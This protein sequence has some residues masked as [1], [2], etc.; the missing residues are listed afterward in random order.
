MERSAVVD[1]SYWLASTPR[2]HYPAPDK[3]V[4]A[5][6]AVVG[7]GIAGLCTAWD[8]VRSGLDV[9]L[10]EADR[11]AAGVSGYTTAK[12][13]A[14]HGLV[15]A[16]LE[17]KQGADA[18]RLY[19]LS[20]QDAVERT[21]ELC[22]DLRID[23]DL[24][25][26]PAFT[27][28]QDPAR[29]PELQEEAAA[30]RRAGL[31]ASFV[32]DTELPFAI[33]GAVRVD[34][35]LQ[36][37]PR[38][39][40]LALAEHLTRAGGRVFERARVTGLHDSHRCR[41]TTETGATVR[42]RDVVIATHYPVFDRTLL[43]T[44]LTPR[45]E[46]VLAAP[47]PSAAAPAGMYLTPEGGVRSLRSAPYDEERRLAIVTGESFTPGTGD[48]SERFD[49][50]DSWARAHV[51]H[52]DRADSGYRWAAQDNDSLDHVPY[53]GH[54]HPGTQHVYVAT[55][56]GGWGMSNGVMA[57]RL[58]S[59]H[60]TGAPRPAWTELYDPRRLPPIRDAGRLAAHQAAV[61]K[62]FVGDRLH[63]GHV[64]SVGDISPGN[65][66]VVRLDGRRC[67]VHRDASGQV[68]ALSARCTH[69]GCLVHFNDAEQAWECPC[70]GSRFATDGSV[71]HGPATRPLEPREVPDP[72]A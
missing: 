47:V 18:A 12:L 41:L 29:V 69:L 9:V 65:G 63:T 2:T 56:F 66:A 49:R 8:L 57:G 5:D 4:T 40:L 42:T 6:V 7:G 16:P 50:L 71:L 1:E 22:A 61:A 10:L 67:A 31:D 62:H 38:K 70:H 55:G 25:R 11:I 23:A 14:A 44:R 59:A 35:Q 68:S 51:P 13:S 33:A 72:P 60:I 27:Y 3:D 39:F 15:Y 53:V 52:F 37:H 19:A 24:E 46:L 45:R 28:L 36:F 43:F 26:A 54:A 30:A 48:V 58:L 17:A 32:T 64:D 20:Q 34:G 21:A